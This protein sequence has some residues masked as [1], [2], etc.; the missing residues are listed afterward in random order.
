MI[1][2]S[3][4]IAPQRRGAFSRFSMRL[5]TLEL[6]YEPPSI[7][8]DSNSG[9]DFEDISFDSES[10]SDGADQEPPA[11]SLSEPPSGTSTPR[12]KYSIV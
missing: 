1:A 12:T 5:F 3:T 11:L 8:M 9:S 6:N 2:L 4:N 7:N 10:S